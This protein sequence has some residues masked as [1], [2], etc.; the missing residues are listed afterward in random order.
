V[1]TSSA[2]RKDLPR[3]AQAVISE[4]IDKGL[5]EGHAVHPSNGVSPE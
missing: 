4:A 2:A 3:A 1:L 5:I